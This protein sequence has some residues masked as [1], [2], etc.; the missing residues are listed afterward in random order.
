MSLYTYM[1]SKNKESLKDVE[2]QVTVAHKCY[3]ISATKVLESREMQTDT[4]FDCELRIPE[5]NYA[6]R[7][8]IMYYP[9]FPNPMSGSATSGIHYRRLL[10]LLCLLA[11]VSA[12][13][14]V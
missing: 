8:S 3:D 11:L 1:D 2:V 14:S 4:M 6:V 5:A 13:V 12:T 10:V 9:G 7:R